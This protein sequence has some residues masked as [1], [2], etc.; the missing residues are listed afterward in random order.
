MERYD[1]TRKQRMIEYAIRKRVE[2]N[3]EFKWFYIGNFERW[4]DNRKLYVE[5][6]DGTTLWCKDAISLET[7]DYIYITDKIERWKQDNKIYRL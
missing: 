7:D 2:D 4:G 1:L 3:P 6:P 5:W